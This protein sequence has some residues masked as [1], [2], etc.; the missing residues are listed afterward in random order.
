MTSPNDNGKKKQKPI[1]QVTISPEEIARRKAAAREKVLANTLKSKHMTKL[2]P[3]ER[4]ELKRREEA[5]KLAAYQDRWETSHCARMQFCRYAS[6][7]CLIVSP[8]RLDP[9]IGT[10]SCQQYAMLAVLLNKLLR[11]ACTT[12]EWHKLR[13]I[14]RTFIGA[15]AMSDHRANLLPV[16]NYELPVIPLE[17][18]ALLNKC[19]TVLSMSQL[20]YLQLAL[21]LWEGVV[22]SFDEFGQV[23][24]SRSN[25]SLGRYEPEIRSEFSCLADRLYADEARLLPQSEKLIEVYTKTVSEYYM[26]KERSYPVKCPSVF[27][28]FDI[29]NHLAWESNLIIAIGVT[30]VGVSADQ[31]S[32]DYSYQLGF[33]DIYYYRKGQSSFDLIEEPTEEERSLACIYFDCVS[34][35]LIDRCKTGM[36]SLDKNEFRQAFKKIDLAWLLM[37]WAAGHPDRAGRAEQPTSLMEVHKQVYG[38]NTEREL[39]YNESMLEKLDFNL[40]S[41]DQATPHEIITYGLSQATANNQVGD[42]YFNDISVEK[43]EAVPRTTS[44]LYFHI[45]HVY[46]SIGK[47][48]EQR[49]HLIQERHAAAGPG[50]TPPRLGRYIF[51]A[52][53]SGLS[54]VSRTQATALQASTK[55]LQDYLANYPEHKVF[56]EPVASTTAKT[57]S[58]STSTAMAR[59]MS[60]AMSAERVDRPQFQLATALVK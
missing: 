42:C 28:T 19:E 25:A 52:S 39:M 7:A 8:Q 22:L 37:S 54:C 45:V 49:L 58:T 3:E 6:L 41:E 31:T 17:V 57:T 26:D 21:L 13:E 1:K 23:C 14:S 20:R 40:P 43:T 30:R 34:T 36:S 9:I 59:R 27:T 60:C 53:K 35:S 33:C 56:C 51:T 29:N 2:S 16:V 10:A 12:S 4:M 48:E 15:T 46:A 38:E 5:R 32:H 18:Q 55:R 50:Q 24:R 47:L 11:Q 44:E